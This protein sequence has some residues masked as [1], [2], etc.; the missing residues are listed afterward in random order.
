MNASE[1]PG[2][3]QKT[4]STRWTV[5]TCIY[6]GVI[7]PGLGTRVWGCGFA[8]Q[9]SSPGSEYGQGPTSSLPHWPKVASALLKSEVRTFELSP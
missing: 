1:S 6:L 2:I 8:V 4:P 5:P 9:A 3:A 7:E